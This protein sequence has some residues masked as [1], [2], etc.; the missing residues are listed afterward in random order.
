MFIRLAKR[1]IYAAGLLLTLVLVP[2]AATEATEAASD[3]DRVELIL[4]NLPPKD[5]PEYKALKDL[6]GNPDVQI[7]DVTKCQMW[8]VLS[9]HLEAVLKAAAEKGVPVIRLDQNW[10]RVLAPYP[11]APAMTAAQEDMMHKTMESKAAVGGSMMAPPQANVTEYALTK[12]MNTGQPGEPAATVIIPLNDKATVTAQRTSVTKIGDAYLWRGVVVG[13]GDLVTLMWRPNGKLT[14]L[15]GTIT[16]GGHKY[17]VK[18]MGGELHGVVEMAPTMMPPDHQPMSKEMMQKLNMRDDPLVKQGDASSVLLHQGGG[19]DT[20]QQTHG[21][22]KHLEDAPL[23]KEAPVP[24]TFG[25]VTSNRV[26][27]P[28]PGDVTITLI[29]AYTKQAA[30]H[31]NDIEK[32]LIALAIEEANQSFR[33]S[34]IDN[35]NIKLVHAYMTDYVESGS[36]FDHL[37][38]FYTDHDGYMDEIFGLRAQYHANIAMLV[39]HD[40]NGCGISAMV[41]PPAD[42]AFA[43]VHHECAALEYSLAH[44]IGHLIGARHDL[45]EDDTMTP[46]PFGHGFI[47]GRNNWRDIMSY[48]ESCGGCPRLPV[49]SNPDV[50]IND[51]AVGDETLRDNAKVIRERA[52]LVARFGDDH[53]GLGVGS[54]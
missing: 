54:R 43:V 6:A 15:T 18:P 40:P 3:K 24:E 50:R 47:D 23:S 8:R 9:S 45:S 37:Y 36:H 39:V 29:V 28:K 49:W 48:K 5:S 33:D 21:D 51:E 19:N 31:Y 27:A 10:N 11:T 30:S 41:A 17:A 7:L 20:L 32:D 13:S 53:P 25:P 16:Y 12:G 42:K 46:F 26:N 22:L 4:S 44:E 35:V 2:S 1:V 38:R 14:T 52:S 34:G